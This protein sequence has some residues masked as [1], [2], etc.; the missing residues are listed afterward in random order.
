MKLI[1]AA[2]GV[3]K[4]SKPFN[5]ILHGELDLDNSN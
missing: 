4:S 5:F 3:L 1:H 2:F